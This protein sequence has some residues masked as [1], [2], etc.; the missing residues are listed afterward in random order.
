MRALRIIDDT[1]SLFA[2]HPIEFY[3][4]EIGLLAFGWNFENNDLSESLAK[5]IDGEFSALR[6]H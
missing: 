3:A 5:K 4:R 1:G 6:T 2:P